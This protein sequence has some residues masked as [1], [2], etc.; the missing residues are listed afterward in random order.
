MLCEGIYICNLFFSMP[1]LIWQCIDPIAHHL[2]SY[3]R[4]ALLCFD[5]RTFFLVCG[6]WFLSSRHRYRAVWAGV[7]VHPSGGCCL[8]H[9]RWVDRWALPPLPILHFALALIATLM[10][11]FF[12]ES[13]VIFHLFTLMSRVSFPLPINRCL[14]FWQALWVMARV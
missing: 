13:C 14:L 7:R 9:H 4:I 10:L 2:A 8:Y 12:I 6:C 3:F 5:L 1:H 11:R